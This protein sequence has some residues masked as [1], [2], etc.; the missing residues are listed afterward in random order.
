LALRLICFRGR[1]FESS[2]AR[3]T[4]TTPEQSEDNRQFPGGLT[5]TPIGRLVGWGQLVDNGGDHYI[6]VRDLAMQFEVTASKGFEADAIGGI[7]VAICC[8]IRARPVRPDP[9]SDRPAQPCL[10]LDLS[11]ARERLAVRLCLA[12]ACDPRRA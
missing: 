6:Q 1:T 11:T 10:S 8:Q 7:Q 5:L 4:F 3:Q 12:D 9:H 2:S